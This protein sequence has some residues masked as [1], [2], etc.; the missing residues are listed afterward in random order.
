VQLGEHLGEVRAKQNWRLEKWK[1]FDEFLEKRFPESRRKAYY[2]MAIHENLKQVLK[3]A[4]QRFNRC[5]C[6]GDLALFRPAAARISLCFFLSSV[7][8]SMQ[9]SVM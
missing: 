6:F 9:G 2:L 5:G 4:R 3:L 7:F 1:S 8:S